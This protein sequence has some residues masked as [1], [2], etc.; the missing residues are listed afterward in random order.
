MRNMVYN[1]QNE[2]KKIIFKKRAKEK[3]IEH[4]CAICEMPTYVYSDKCSFCST[5]NRLKRQ[6]DKG[7]DSSSS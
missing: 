2:M 5:V 6:M 3:E 1:Y 4:Y 7:Y